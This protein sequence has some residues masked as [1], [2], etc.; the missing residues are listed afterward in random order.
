ML[1]KAY[2]AIFRPEEGGGFFIDFPDIQGAYTGINEDDIVFG[3]TMAEEVLGM[4]L[5]DYIE[6]NDE[7]PT[8]TPIYDI[9]VQKNGAF[10][11]LVK[12]DL[13]KYLRD[14]TVIKKT[15][16]IPLWAD[17]IAKRLDINFSQTLTEAILQKITPNQK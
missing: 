4:V 6:N 11:T 15:L 8:A 13:E 7:I 9:P 17:K 10:V 16:T 2:P 1:L 3:L 14:S 5:A 12:V